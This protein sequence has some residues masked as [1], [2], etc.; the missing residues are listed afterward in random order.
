MAHID[1]DKER[2]AEFR[3]LDD[4]GAIDMLN[5]VRFAARAELDGETMTGAQAYQRYSERSAPI[6]QRVGGEIIASWEPRLTLIGPARERWDAAFIA[7]YP[8][9]ASFLSMLADPAYQSAVR[10]R[11][12]AVADS[13]LIRLRARERAGAFG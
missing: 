5:L 2:F 9:A 6:F 1:P 13:R 8:S 10:Y 4:E 3:A 11:T 7:R 12:A